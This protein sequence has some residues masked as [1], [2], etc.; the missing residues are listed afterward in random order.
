MGCTLSSPK[1]SGVSTSVVF[2]QISQTPRDVNFPLRTLC[3]CG[4]SEFPHLRQIC[5]MNIMRP[6]EVIELLIRY[7]RRLDPLPAKNL[8]PTP[9]I[10]DQH[11]RASVSSSC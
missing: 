3:R 10:S 1:A 7:N 5:V 2:L 8:F 9:W 4:C 11:P 6:P